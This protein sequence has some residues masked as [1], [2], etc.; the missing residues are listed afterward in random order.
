[1]FPLIKNIYKAL[2]YDFFTDTELFRLVPGSD[3]ARHAII[4]RGIAK[5]ELIRIRR[6]VYCLGE[7]W[8]RKPVNNFALAHRCYGPSYI[9]LESAL[10][11][12]E[13]IPE[14]VY[15][16]TSACLKR[17]MEFHSK[18]GSFAYIRNSR[19]TMK[20]V[21]RI[22]M[23]IFPVLMATPA[24]A[25]LDYVFLYKK[26]WTTTEPLIKSLRIVEEDLLK[27]PFDS[28][29]ALL[30]DYRNKSVDKFIKGIQKEFFE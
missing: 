6:G 26:K 14:G 8:I 25:I 15:T 3:N 18:A 19:F 22:L 20:G 2:P 16:T 27:I 10:S 11:Y 21:E 5:N 23:D 13:L 17:S 1:M 4:K 28:F 12:H 9:S 24:K 7:S 30:P 29:S